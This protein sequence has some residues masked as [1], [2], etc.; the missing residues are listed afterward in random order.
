MNRLRI[1]V[2]VTVMAVGIC[3]TAVGFFLLLGKS[4]TLAW[5]RLVVDAGMLVAIGVAVWQ[6]LRPLQDRIDEVATMLRSYAGGQRHARLQPETFGALDDLARATNEVGAA[7]TDHIDANLGP[8]RARL[9]DADETDA[10]TKRE[11]DQRDQIRVPTPP[12][13][14]WQGGAPSPMANAS[15]EVVRAS[16]ASRTADDTLGEVRLRPK[17]K[18]VDV[19]THAVDAASN[20]SLEARDPNAAAVEEV[21]TAATSQDTIID[22]AAP[23]AVTIEPAAASTA[24][25]QALFDE[26]V[27]QRRAN[28]PSGQ[29]AEELDFDAFA[30]TIHAESQR[31][32]TAHGCKAV[33]FEVLIADGDVSLRPRLL[34]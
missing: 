32:V 25:L 20:T 6:S 21:P 26:F 18:T 7:M 19:D 23:R 11:R 33:R 16:M 29:P 10:V 13:P 3:A 34:R 28:A 27:A 8:V 12:K 24:E 2:L 14:P 15:S 1:Q 22:Q 17:G 31:L 30:E 5:Q 4:D 9:R